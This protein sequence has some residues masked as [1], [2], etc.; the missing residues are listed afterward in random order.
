MLSMKIFFRAVITIYFLKL[1][2]YFNLHFTVNF[3]PERKIDLFFL[4]QWHC[5][6]NTDAPLIILRKQ[7]ERRIGTRAH[8][9]LHIYL[10]VS[11]LV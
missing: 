10:S 2:Y 4:M 1:L 7:D 9:S 5:M 11:L 3:L 6:H 8:L